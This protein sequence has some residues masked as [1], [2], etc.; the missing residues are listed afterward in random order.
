ML[1]QHMQIHIFER[2]DFSYFMI[3]I[4]SWG[5]PHFPLRKALQDMLVD[6]L[7]LLDRN[8]PQSNIPYVATSA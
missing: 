1:R 5:H 2:G 7:E 3:V 6:F 8:S 4:Q